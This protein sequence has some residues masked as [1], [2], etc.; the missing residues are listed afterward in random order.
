M[1]LITFLSLCVAKIYVAMV[2]RLPAIKA[3]S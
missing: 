1:L 3:S 2:S